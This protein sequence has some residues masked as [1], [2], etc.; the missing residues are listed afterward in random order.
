MV[1]NNQP[2]YTIKQQQQQ[3]HKTTTTTTTTTKTKTTS[4]YIIMIFYHLLSASLATI[5]LSVPSHGHETLLRGGRLPYVPELS[6]G[7]ITSDGSD[8][9]YYNILP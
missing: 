8:S 6:Q 1:N 5:L 4:K 7:H 3:T 9:T 2:Q